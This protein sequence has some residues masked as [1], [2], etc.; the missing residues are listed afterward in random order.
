MEQKLT[1]KKEEVKTCSRC[2]RTYTGYGAI[3]RKDNKMEIC[4]E[5]GQAE[6]LEVFRKHLEEQEKEKEA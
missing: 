1:Q 6:A 3:S 5:C 4:S 2:N